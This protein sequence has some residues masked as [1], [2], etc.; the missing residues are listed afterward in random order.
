MNEEQI[1]QLIEAIAEDFTSKQLKNEKYMLYRLK[2]LLGYEDREAE[3]I[4]WG[5]REMKKLRGDVVPSWARALQ[6]H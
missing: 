6:R 4:L 1:G 5:A 3:A 2:F